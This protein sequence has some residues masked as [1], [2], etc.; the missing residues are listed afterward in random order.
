MMGETTMKAYQYFTAMLVLL[1]GV[2]L[3]ATQVGWSQPVSTQIQLKQLAPEQIK[4]NV[5]LSTLLKPNARWRV[6]QLAPAEVNTAKFQSTTGRLLGTQQL[7]GK[8]AESERRLQY[9]DPQDASMFST[10][11]KQTGH[12]SFQKSLAKYLGESIPKLPDA[13]SA[14]NMAMEFL[15]K[16]DFAPKNQ[17]ELKMVHAG[18]VRMTSMKNGRGGP[19]IDKLRTFSYARM[20]E[21]IPV[22]GG[23]SKIVVHVGDG[24]EIVGMNRRWR[25][26]TQVRTVEPAELKDPK[27]AEKEMREF[28]SREFGQESPQLEISIS[29][30]E[31]LYYDG[32][33]G[34]FI[35][36]A[37]MYEAIISGGGNRYQY[38]GAISALKQPPEQIGPGQIPPEAQSLIKMMKPEQIQIDKKTQE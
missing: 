23:G 32:G 5:N 38:F 30:V 21:G 15:R 27:Q 9:A 26:V 18:G 7:R 19:V 6:Y 36:P 24:G 14:E 8:V 11:D 17:A 16:N 34:K 37:Y 12:L 28:L 29:K 20:L 1:L 4:L 13:K 35:Q 25:E 3:L 31:L 22:Q 2:M 10:Q 33:D